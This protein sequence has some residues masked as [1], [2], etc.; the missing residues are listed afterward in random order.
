MQQGRP[1]AVAYLGT[2]AFDNTRWSQGLAENGFRQL[3][4]AQRNNVA[5]RAESRPQGRNLL[6]R[7][8]RGA[9]NAP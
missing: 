7:V 1:A 2:D 6:N 3:P 8:G 5:L 9:V 4:P